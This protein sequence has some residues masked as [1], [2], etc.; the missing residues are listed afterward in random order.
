MIIEPALSA[1]RKPAAGF[2]RLKRVVRKMKSVQHFWKY[3]TIAFVFGVAGMSFQN[4]ITSK[5]L[6]GVY[7]YHIEVTA[8]DAESGKPIDQFGFILPENSKDDILHQTSGIKSGNNTEIFGVAYEPREW[9]VVSEGFKD[10]ILA[11]ERSTPPSLTIEMQP[12]THSNTDELTQGQQDGA[13]NW[14]RAPR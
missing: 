2:L 12:K 13:E 3:A 14:H 6:E 10:T 1:Y 4:W 8:V 7:H 5:K 9:I 11:V